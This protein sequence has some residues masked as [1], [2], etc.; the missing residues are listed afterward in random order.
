MICHV[1]GGRLNKVTTDL[2]FK[3]TQNSIIIIK[4]LPVLQCQ[5]CQEYLIEDSIMAKVDHL[6]SRMDDT[7]E[8]EI[9][10]FAV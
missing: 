4:D 2:P 8:L 7:T 9:L 5:N 3:I 10:K 6:L 1:C